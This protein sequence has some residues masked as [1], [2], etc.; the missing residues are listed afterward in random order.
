MDLTMPFADKGDRVDFPAAKQGDNSMSLE[1]GFTSAYGLPPEEGGLFIDR[2]K[3][4]QLM[5]LVSKGVIDNKTAL[6]NIT[7]IVNGISGKYMELLTENKTYY[8]GPNKGDDFKD[9]DEAFYYIQRYSLNSGGRNIRLTLRDNFE[10][11]KPYINMNGMN[12]NCVHVTQETLDD[13]KIYYYDYNKLKMI[14]GP[15]LFFFHSSLTPRLNFNFSFTKGSGDVNN[16]NFMYEESCITQLLGFYNPANNDNYVY[17]I[18]KNSL[19]GCNNALTINNSIAYIYNINIKGDL[20]K[21]NS[22]PSTYSNHIGCYK[23][24]F[25]NIG[26]VSLENFMCGIFVNGAD[27]SIENSTINSN[28]TTAIIMNSN[29]CM[30]SNVTINQD[31][32]NFLTINNGAILS[33]ISSSLKGKANINFTQGQWSSDG[34]FIRGLTLPS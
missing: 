26:K 28:K 4:N 29:N 5:Y 17:E 32:G 33:A 1:Q 16:A 25:V 14:Y 3:F 19:Y 6:D 12:L 9:I 23:G 27:I 2:Q 13:T 7:P 30:L 10:F 21:H 34:G 15:F 22:T 31:E 11:L 18:Y 24:A 8:I 20:E